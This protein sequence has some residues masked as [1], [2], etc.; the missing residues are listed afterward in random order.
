MWLINLCVEVEGGQN[1]GQG[2]GTDSVV[3]CS[4]FCAAVCLSILNLPGN[5]KRCFFLFFFFFFSLQ[6]YHALCAICLNTHIN[7]SVWCRV[8]SWLVWLVLVKVCEGLSSCDQYVDRKMQW[9]KTSQ[10]GIVGMNFLK[11]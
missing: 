2:C 7:D 9:E 3:W 6:F 4:P 10:V 5:T 1:G 8:C 11:L